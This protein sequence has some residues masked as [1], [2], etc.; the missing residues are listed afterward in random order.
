MANPLTFN[1]DCKLSEMEV[2][3]TRWQVY[4]SQI[5]IASDKKGTPAQKQEHL[6]KV[7]DF[8][9]HLHRVLDRVMAIESGTKEEAKDIKGQLN[10]GETSEAK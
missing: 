8:L 4:G 2:F 7:N 3:K 6:N 10:I 5:L 9:N 1:Q